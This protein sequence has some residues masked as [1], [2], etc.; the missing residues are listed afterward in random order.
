MKG[1][2]K[3][4]GLIRAVPEFKNNKVNEKEVCELFC[5]GLLVD[6]NLS[7]KTFS[8]FSTFG[9]ITKLQ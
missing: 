5:Q 1:I 8:N 9:R 7:L 4:P 3:Q 6:F 2:K